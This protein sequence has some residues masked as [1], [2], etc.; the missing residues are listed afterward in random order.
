MKNLILILAVVIVSIGHANQITFE[1]S[2]KA[3]IDGFTFND[4]SSFK[5][6]KSNGHWKNS[7][8]DYG[9]HQCMGTVTS[10]KN[11]KGGINVYCKYTSQNDDYFF[12]KIFRDSEYQ[13]S[14]AGKAIIVETSDSYKF[15]LGTG[16]THAVT[17]LKSDYFA[18]QK[19]KY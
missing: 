5:L 4:T 14:G 16:C 19:C 17:Y 15:L 1:A 10:N 9:L 7:T 3:N 6:Y 13:D 2:G 11:N 12:M 18:M 8:G